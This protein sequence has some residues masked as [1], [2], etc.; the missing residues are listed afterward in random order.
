MQRIAN[1]FLVCAKKEVVNEQWPHV[2]LDAFTLDEVGFARSAEAVRASTSSGVRPDVWKLYSCL[3]S[4]VARVHRLQH[5]CV[6]SVLRV[7]RPAFATVALNSHRGDRISS[8]SNQ[9]V[10]ELVREPRVIVNFEV[11]PWEDKISSLL[12]D[13]HF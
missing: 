2:L 4:N 13:T 1:F 9:I 5:Q 12:N 10:K 3:V 8:I 6:R 11:W 7:K